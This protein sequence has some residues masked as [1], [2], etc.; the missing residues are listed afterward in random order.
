LFGRLDALD[1]SLCTL[2]HQRGRA[3][4]LGGGFSGG[5]FFS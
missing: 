4:S 2:L 5:S 1:F 3:R